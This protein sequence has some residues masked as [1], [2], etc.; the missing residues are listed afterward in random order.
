MD[1]YGESSQKSFPYHTVSYKSNQLFKVITKQNY[2]N[3]RPSQARV[4]NGSLSLE[5]KIGMDILYIF[6]NFAT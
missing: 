1:D 6:T 4:S 5:L 2:Q 3:L